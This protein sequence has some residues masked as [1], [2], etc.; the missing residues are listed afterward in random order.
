MEL[1]KVVYFALMFTKKIKLKKNKKPSSR[2]V[3]ICASFILFKFSV[4]GFAQSLTLNNFLKK[5]SIILKNYGLMLPLQKSVNYSLPSTSGFFLKP[6]DKND[7]PFFCRIE[8]G[9][10]KQR[11]IPVKFRLGDVQYVDQLEGK[12]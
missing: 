4:S 11:N 12:H 5:D 8:Y 9:M 3:F 7:L 1:L 6:F 2:Y 10:I